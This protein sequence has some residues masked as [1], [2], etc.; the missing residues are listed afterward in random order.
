MQFSEAPRSLERLDEMDPDPNAYTLVDIEPFVSN[1]FEILID[2]W[3]VSFPNDDFPFLRI[4]P[5]SQDYLRCYV[6]MRSNNFSS[7]LPKKCKS[8]LSCVKTSK[9]LVETGISTLAPSKS[10]PRSTPKISRI[11]IP[12][13]QIDH[14][15]T[16]TM[17]LKEVCRITLE[18]T[19]LIE[20][21]LT[22]FTELADL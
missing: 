19:T 14:P 16:P 8:L 13:N 3:E 11:H 15:F 10:R 7:L 9:N 21:S 18:I 2:A 1:F 6:P 4:Y 22:H 20:C 5:L 17:K 12:S